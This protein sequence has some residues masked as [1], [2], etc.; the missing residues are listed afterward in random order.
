MVN[1]EFESTCLAFRSPAIR[2]ESPPLTQEEKSDLVKSRE[3]KRHAARIIAALPS[4]YLCSSCL[5]LPEARDRYSMVVHT[6]TDNQRC[7]VVN[8]ICE[9]TD[10]T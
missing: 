5:F 10:L 1:L 8:I 7:S 2:T 4:N 6:P 3:G 9:P